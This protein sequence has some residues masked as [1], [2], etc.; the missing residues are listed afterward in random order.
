M[1]SRVKFYS[2]KSTFKGCRPYCIQKNL[3]EKTGINYDSTSDTNLNQVELAIAQGNLELAANLFEEIKRNSR[4]CAKRILSNST[5]PLSSRLKRISEQAV[6]QKNPERAKNTW[7][8]RSFLRQLKK[9]CS[10]L[11]GLCAQ[12]A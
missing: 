12:N 10:S 5:R 2:K 8:P 3:F 7:I 1:P 11:R 6:A 9:V 4:K